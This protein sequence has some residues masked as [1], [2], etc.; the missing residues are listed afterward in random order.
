MQASHVDATS[1]SPEAT[2]T[3][4][5]DPFLL[6]PDELHALASEPVVARGIAY[7]S[8]H[9]VTDLLQTGDSLSATVDGSGRH[10]Y[11]VHLHTEEDGL[12]CSC[13]CSFDWEP[14]CKHGIATL[15]AWRA[16]QEREDV[17]LSSANSQAIADR[18]R[19]ASTEVVVEFVSGQRHFGTWRARS[20]NTGVGG[21]R[22]RV[23]IRSL[24]K[25]LNS[26]TCPDFQLNQLGTCKHIEAVKLRLRTDAAPEPAVAVAWLDWRGGAGAV[27]RVHRP[28]Q[29]SAEIS[30]LIDGFTEPD[31]RLKGGDPTAVFRLRDAAED[32]DGLVITEELRA[33]AERSLAKERA[34]RRGEELAR[35]IRHHG[36]QLPGLKARLHP[37]QVD[38]VAFLASRGRALLADDM[39]L[40][41]TLQAIAACQV[42]MQES[43]VERVL[44][45][46]PAS[47]KGQWE[48]EI[49]RFTGRS[50]QVVQGGAKARLAQYRVHAAFTIVNYEVVLRDFDVIGSALGMDVLVLDEAQRIRNWKT[51]TAAAVKR[52]QSRY[53]FV[54]TG[55]PLENRLVD[56]YSV[57]QVVEPRA[58]GPL[59]RFMVDFHI[60]DERGKAL[61][62]RN[63]SELR[64]RMAPH[65]LRRNRDI[66]ADQ[67]PARTVV[68]RYLPLSPRQKDLHDA[69][70]LAVRTI[71]ETAKKQHRPLTPS[72][73]TRV[74]AALQQ[75]RMACNAA[76]LV[77]GETEGS[78]KLTELAALLE[79][80]CLD[81]G[82]KVVVFSQWTKMLDM[83]KGVADELGIGSRM[84]DGSVPTAKRKALID[85][86]RHDA[87]VKIFFASDAGATGLNLQVANAVINL[88]L[89]FNPAL[90]AQRIARVH[91]LGQDS[92]C[93][94]TLLVAAGSYEEQIGMSLVNK[95]ALFESTISGE[96]DE[97]VVGLTQRSVQLAMEAAATER[98]PT[99]DGEVVDEDAQDLNVA[100]DDG[101]GEVVEIVVEA[102]VEAAGADTEDGPDAAPGGPGGPKKRA[103]SVS[104]SVDNPSS[105]APL[106]ARLQT[107]LGDRL[108]RVFVAGRGLVAVVD[109]ADE[110]THAA[111]DRLCAELFDREA[112][113]TL[114][115]VVVDPRTWRSLQ[116]LATGVAVGARELTLSETPPPEALVSPLVVLAER[117][118]RAAEVL[119][120]AG[121]GAEA[122]GLL[123]EA[124]VAALAGRCE[125]EVMPAEVAGWLYG[126][127]VPSGRVAPD[128]A[129]LVMQLVGL[130]AMAATGGAGVPEAAI[131]EVLR[132]VR[133]VAAMRGAGAAA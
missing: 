5:A 131:A 31:G 35:Q 67:L 83:A 97:D 107:L 99:Q 104:P 41:K 39:G 115:V 82:R 34:A 109:V 43:G 19:R 3:P 30:G 18:K 14:V 74:L 28:T 50:V 37:Y 10:T 7:A 8:E 1:S 36:G 32:L 4:T 87:T 126:E 20:V 73:E 105:L 13:T 89:P 9:R 90:L 118:L 53:A 56:L 94:I 111:V 91:R 23:E 128:E 47:L 66:V 129:A 132:A 93:L 85:T 78:P 96:G 123:R 106:V 69:A 58:L 25:P 57:M 114:P 24:S 116:A 42:L 75:A 2:A 80:L 29:L 21:R 26:C 48:D 121:C 113:A 103:P 44:V 38:G 102:A 122:L 63:L 127:A 112:D 79:T 81:E 16:E 76:G 65:M 98:R 62:Y 17:D 100:Q 117:K 101:D 68:R 95:Q 133:V 72:E 45:V 59:W 11:A 110:A 77:D 92:P 125:L 54:L 64:L 15:L 12:R 46:C 130:A 60:T 33:W 49:T 86:F 52:L 119:V 6:P 84:L 61:G 108:R 27:P 124:C 88:E 55:T 70:L 71:Y 120:D 22:Y 40:G 51:K